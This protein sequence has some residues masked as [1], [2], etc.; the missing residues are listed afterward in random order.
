MP[1]FEFQLDGV[2]R[3][4][5]HAEQQRQRELAVIQL[6]MTRLKA[7][8]D[9]MDRAVRDTEQDMRDNRLIGRLDLSYLAAHR[10]FAF[11]MQRKAMALAEQMA[12]I[13]IKIN[14]AQRNLSEAVKGRKAIEKLREK[15]FERWREAQARHEI[16]EL[17]EVT[18]QMV[19]HRLESEQQAGVP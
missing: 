14:E 10:R 7:D 17:D 3:Q 19:R 6:Q 13:Q 18:I 1:K 8:L 9:Q 12:A 2:L 4:R 11:S 5:K 16:L 15:Q